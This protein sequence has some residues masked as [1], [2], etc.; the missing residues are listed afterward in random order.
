VSFN[1]L[2]AVPPEIGNLRNIT[3]LDRVL[4]GNRERHNL[5][6]LTSRAFLLAVGDNFLTSLPA[7]IGNLTNLT[8]LNGVCVIATVDNTTIRSRLISSFSGP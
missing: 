6:S 3:A 7:E 2:A 8:H 5:T 4:H 1:Q